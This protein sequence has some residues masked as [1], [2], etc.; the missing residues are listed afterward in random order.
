MFFLNVKEMP[1]VIFYAYEDISFQSVA[2]FAFVAYNAD[3]VYIVTK[4]YKFKL[5][6]LLFI[7]F[8][9]LFNTSK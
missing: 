5:I 6:L 3:T 2:I 9:S 4:W 7:R 1:G 8:Y